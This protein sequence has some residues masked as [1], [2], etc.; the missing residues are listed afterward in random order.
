VSRE[1]V[2]L[3]QDVIAAHE[4]GDFA[5]VFAAYDPGIE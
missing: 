1:N 5:A 3:V 2:E 4:R